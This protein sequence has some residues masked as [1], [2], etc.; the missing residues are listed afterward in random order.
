MTTGTRHDKNALPRRMTTGTRHDK[1]CPSFT[2]FYLL[3]LFG[4]TNAHA[5][6]KELRNFYFFA[7]REKGFFSSKAAANVLKFVLSNVRLHQTSLN[8]PQDMASQK[9]GPQNQI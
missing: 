6:K 5:F 7:T 9:R 3:F 2:T 4:I 1:K 8:I